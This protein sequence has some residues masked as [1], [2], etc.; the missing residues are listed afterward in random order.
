MYADG[1]VTVIFARNEARLQWRQPCAIAR[2]KAI[3][4]RA[5]MTVTWLSAYIV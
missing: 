3:V 1:Y 5:N 4:I 2:V